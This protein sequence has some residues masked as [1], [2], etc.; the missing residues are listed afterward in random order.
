MFWPHRF[1]WLR[2]SE[3]VVARSEVVGSLTL[4]IS[5]INRAAAEVEVTLW[6]SDLTGI[7]SIDGTVAGAP[8]SEDLTFSGPVGSAIAVK[9]TIGKFSALSAIDLTGL[10]DED[11]APEIQIRLCDAAGSPVQA[12][13]EIQAVV[14]GQAEEHHGAGLWAPQVSGIEHSTRGWLLMDNVYGDLPRA[15]DLFVQLLADGTEHETWEVMQG[16]PPVMAGA[17]LELE[18]QRRHQAPTS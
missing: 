13:R 2:V 17:H 16:P 18:I 9:R 6:G 4:A 1:R 5:A 14:L 15:G 12:H 3:Q 11:P 10:A 8:Y 7:V